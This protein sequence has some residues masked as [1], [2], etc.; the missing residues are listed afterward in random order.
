MQLHEAPQEGGSEVRSI[1]EIAEGTHI[2]LQKFDPKTGADVAQRVSFNGTLCSGKPGRSA[3]IRV[4]HRVFVDTSY[5]LTANSTSLVQRIVKQPDGSYH[6]FTVSSAY[7]L[8][9]LTGQPPKK[10]PAEMPQSKPVRRS[11]GELFSWL[12]RRGA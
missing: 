12:K 5:D 6:I 10:E 7:R 2:N 1:P 4:G 3:Q 8:T 11:L 9:V